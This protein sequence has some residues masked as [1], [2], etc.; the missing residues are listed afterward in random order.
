MEEPGV[1]QKE[2]NIQEISLLSALQRGDEEAFNFFFQR[3]N[4]ILYS[5]AFKVMN[6]SEEA[7]EVVQNVFLRLW[8]KRE[9][10]SIDRSV[11]SYLLRCIYNEC[12]NVIKHRKIRFRA[13]DALKNDLLRTS[14]ENKINF[15]GNFELYELVRETVNTLPP[16]RKKVFVLSRYQQLKNREIAEEMNISSKTV[17]NHITKAIKIFRVAL[18]DYIE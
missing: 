17:E 15:C 14:G 2:L 5:Y 11:R 6:D 4:S 1:K 9:K 3:Y 7:K 8:E 10:I 12:F 16:R 13:M 18:L